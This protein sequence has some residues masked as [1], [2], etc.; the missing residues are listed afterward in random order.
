[1]LVC[2]V[3]SQPLCVSFGKSPVCRCC[4]VLPHPITTM[5]RRLHNPGA[6]FVDGL[7]R[8]HCLPELL[9]LVVELLCCSPITPLSHCHR[10]D[11]MSPE[12]NHSSSALPI[13]SSANRQLNQQFG[14][15]I[16]IQFLPNL[17]V[18]FQYTF[19]FMLFWGL[20]VAVSETILQ[21]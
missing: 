15:H 9:L 5:L 3:V 8:A 11:Q 21:D 20:C 12:N 16:Q 10:R 18:S 13:C 1:M 2:P 14:L 17:R 7:A 4:V 19:A 6:S